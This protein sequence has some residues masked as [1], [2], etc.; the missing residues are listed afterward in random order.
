MVTVLLLMSLW[1]ETGD[2]EGR[3]A[4]LVM[5][6]RFA[7]A[8]MMRTALIHGFLDR[9][10]RHASQLEGA[11]EQM[12]TD[13]LREATE[14]ARDAED[15]PE[16]AMATARI[17][18][19]CG[20]CHQSREVTVVVLGEDQPS[21]RDTVRARMGRHIWAADRMWAGLIG[22]DDGAWMRGAELLKSDP[23]LSTA[24]SE[25]IPASQLSALE[26]LASEASVAP[27]W[28]ARADLFGRFLGQCA[29]CHA[30]AEV[31]P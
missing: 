17:A 12:A 20:A 25:T 30:G 22:H 21:W 10:K 24:S 11:V 1:A 5:H 8:T 16:A 9:A 13:T 4:T 29:A 23:F 28:G 26:T 18:D 3:E 27:T 6:E 15:L 2:Y 7:Y 19:A 14:R 31:T